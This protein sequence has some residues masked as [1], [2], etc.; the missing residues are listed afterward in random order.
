MNE[1]K[2]VYKAIERSYITMDKNIYNDII[3]QHK[4][5]K[6]EIIND[7]SLNVKQKSEAIN[8]LNGNY[9]FDKIRYK[10]GKKNFCKDCKNE[11]YANSYCEHCIR[12]YLKENFLNWTSKN[13]KIDNLIRECQL[14]SLAPNRIIE[15]IPYNRLKKVKYFTR[16]GCSEIYKANWI[17]GYYNKWDSK[18]KCL[19]RSGTHKVILKA[20]KNVE[21]ANRSWFDEAVSHLTISNKWAEI[22]LCNGLTQNPENGEYMIVMERMDADLRGY[23]RQNNKTLTWERRIKIAFDIIEALYFIHEENVIHRDLHSGNVL[24]FHGYDSWYISDLG[25]CGPADNPLNSIYGNL[26]YIAPE[27]I[28]GKE[29]TQASDIYS[30]GMIMWE[31]SSGYP[32]FYN[33]KHNYNMAMKIVNGSRPTILEGTP[34]EYKEL[35]IQCWNEKSSERPKINTLLD[36]I[37]KMWKNCYN[38]IELNTLKV[39][40]ELNYYS[41]Q[42]SRLYY[43]NSNSTSKIYYSNDLPCKDIMDEQEANHSKPYDFKIES[44]SQNS[45]CLI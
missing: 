19:I 21:S 31:I 24:Y 22:V 45:G 2:L 26:P 34:S 13:D 5:R 15:W 33:C 18:E 6:Q 11:Y 10:I 12:I 39:N 7:K 30:I 25:F 17:D 28:L 36:K 3:K 16:G 38:N 9:N 14:Q 43:S 23:L 35:M 32:P 42:N 20:L 27:V 8:N 41:P 4:F 44:L 40:L 37:E 29:Y 1:L